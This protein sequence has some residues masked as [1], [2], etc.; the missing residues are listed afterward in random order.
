MATAELRDATMV[1]VH[2]SSLTHGM[3]VDAVCD[4]LRQAGVPYSLT[5]LPSP[6]GRWLGDQWTDHG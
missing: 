2:V 1:M 3:V 5:P 4:V 6:Q